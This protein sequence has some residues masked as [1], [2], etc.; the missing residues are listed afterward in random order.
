MKTK[1][2]RVLI[3][4]FDGTISK[5]DFFWYVIDL[6]LAKEDISPW[7]DYLEKKISHIEA[8]SRIFR[9]IR[10][11]EEEFFNFILSLPIEECFV[12]TVHYCHE[13]NI[14]FYIISAGADFYIKYILQHLKV[15]N[16]VKLISNESIYKPES[17]LIINKPDKSREFY[18]EN[19]GV[20]KKLAVETIKKNYDFA[21]YAGD[22]RP[23]FEAAKAA[24]KV[25]AKD[26]LL[27]LCQAN[28]VQS[29]KF[30]NYCEILEYLKND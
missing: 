1:K 27:E 19:Y 16:M 12:E 17:G 2:N 14:G 23:D 6:L 11:G 30:D 22:G 3:S 7:N 9:K 20:N 4:D 15:D 26:A 13:N 24:D 8:L 5:K 10:L 21:I 28:G 25:F 18:S 29:S